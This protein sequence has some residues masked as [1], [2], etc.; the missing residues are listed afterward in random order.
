MRVG[1]EDC[2]ALAIDSCNTA[3]SPTGFAEIVCNGFPVLHLTR[4]ETPQL[5]SQG[6]VRE[7]ALRIAC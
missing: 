6:G 3:P 7:D 1:D 5:L 2:S 4:T